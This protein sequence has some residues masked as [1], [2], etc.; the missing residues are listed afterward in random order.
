MAVRIK[1]GKLTM[2]NIMNI[3]YDM[4]KSRQEKQN[5]QREVKSDKSLNER[6]D[7]LKSK[8]QNIF[9]DIDTLKR[10]ANYDEQPQFFE[11]WIDEAIEVYKEQGRIY[12]KQFD[13]WLEASKQFE[14]IAG[15][16]FVD[17]QICRAKLC[18]YMA[19]EIGLMK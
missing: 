5:E 13:I 12:D 8:L 7:E 10:I 9:D 3:L 16:D 1:G 19:K 4:K 11:D 17:A 15:K 18:Q 14:R 2:S 6:N